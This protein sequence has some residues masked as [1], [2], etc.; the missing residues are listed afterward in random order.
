MIII[1]IS[2][3]YFS[4]DIISTKIKKISVY[5]KRIK[6]DQEKLNSAKVLNEQ[7]QQ[8]SKVI[9]NSITTDRKFNSEEV[10]NFVKKLATLS[11]QYKIAVHSL[12]PKVVSSIGSKYVEQQYTME[13]DCTFIQMGQFLTDLESYDNII[14]VNTLDV[15]PLSVDS[16][17]T[18]SEEDLV[19][20]YKVTLELS[21][22]KIIKEA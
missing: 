9:V 13:L 11:D 16:K 7:L 1:T 12:F 6:R 20:H 19:T 2:F 15:R 22:F 10:N 5:D 8:V 18:S 4:S 14:K 21:T 3:F 17:K